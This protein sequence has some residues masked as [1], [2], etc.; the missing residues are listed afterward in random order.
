MTYLSDTRSRH[1]H[2]ARAS[3]KRKLERMQEKVLRTVFLDKTSTYEQLLVKANLP[4]L[5]NRRLQDILTLMYKVKDSMAPSY[6]C[7]LVSLSN[8]KYNLRKSDFNLPS[9]KTVSMLITRIYL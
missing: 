8:K 5:D 3:D 4:S 2:F 6:L 7:D 9:F 1:W